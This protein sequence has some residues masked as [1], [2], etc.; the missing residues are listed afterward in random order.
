MYFL[1]R[2]YVQSNKKKI[3]IYFPSPKLIA[4]NQFQRDANVRKICIGPV[5]YHINISATKRMNEG[6]SLPMSARMYTIQMLL[7]H[8]LHRFPVEQLILNFQKSSFNGTDF[9]QNNLSFNIGAIFWLKPETHFKISIDSYYIR[10][11]TCKE[12]T[13]V[14]IKVKSR[15][16]HISCS[17]CYCYCKISYK[18]IAELSYFLP[19]SSEIE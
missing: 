8:W 18:N 13:F 11:N 7:S 4:G 12:T 9:V 10:I 1:K 16:F 6:R 14:Y 5:R 2:S 3:Y 17:Y 15:M 19:F